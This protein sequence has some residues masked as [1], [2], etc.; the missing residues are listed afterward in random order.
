MYLFSGHMG[1]LMD[2]TSVLNLDKIM[3]RIIGL[4]A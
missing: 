1:N 3:I 4:K 2:F